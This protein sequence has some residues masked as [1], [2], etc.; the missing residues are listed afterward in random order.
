MKS[1]YRVVILGALVTLGGCELADTLLPQVKE[2]GAEVGDRLLDEAEWYICN[3]A[4]VGAIRRRY[5]KDEASAAAYNKRCN[6]ADTKII[7]G[8]S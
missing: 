4:R 5:G 6:T 1:L 2:R 3:G 8:E 7:R